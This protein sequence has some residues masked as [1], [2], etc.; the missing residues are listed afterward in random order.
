MIDEP[1]LEFAATA[2]A[3]VLV[4][5]A[6]L[7]SRG[8]AGLLQRKR[9][10]ES[11]R[12][13]DLIG[14]VLMAGAALYV[15]RTQHATPWFLAAAGVALLAQLAGFY[16]RKSEQSRPSVGPSVEID[17]DADEDL[18]AC[19]MCG[20]GTLIEL[21]DTSRL[22]AGLTQLTPLTAAV[23][24]ECGALS[25]QVEDPAQIPIGPEHGTTLQKSPSSDDQQ[26]LEEPA[27]HDG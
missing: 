6:L 1:S 16:F 5:R 9:R 7:L 23:C 22:M 8:G 25:G 26:A 4:L 18:V 24:P 15:W 27:E 10:V 3:L 12:A 11:A 13:R 19:P 17:E 2:V 20:H 21:D 14:L